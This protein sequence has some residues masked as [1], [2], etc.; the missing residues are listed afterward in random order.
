MRI[1]LAVAL[2]ALGVLSIQEA[3]A[4]HSFAMFDNQ[5]EVSVE[6]VIRE[7]QWTNPH[8]WIRMVSMDGAGKEVEWNIEGQSPNGLIRAGWSR[9]AI[10]PGDKA[11]VVI[12]P[13]KDGS[14][15]GSVV[16]VSVNG[17][18]IG[19][20]APSPAERPATAP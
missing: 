2:C 10:K 9:D 4:H 20:P 15:G 1:P 17:H 7:F 5:R 13:L 19:D 12:H 8:C 16:R 11:I 3:S 14:N 6:G 18:P